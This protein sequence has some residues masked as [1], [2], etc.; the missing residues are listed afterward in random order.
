MAASAATPTS[1]SGLNN[2]GTVQ[3]GDGF[4]DTA[5]VG[6][7]SSTKPVNHVGFT[8]P[9][10]S[11]DDEM[12]QIMVEI[13]DMQ[14]LIDNNTGDVLTIAKEDMVKSQQALSEKK[15]TST[16]I[17][18]EIKVIDPVVPSIQLLDTNTALNSIRSISAGAIDNLDTPVW[19][20]SQH[21]KRH[22][23]VS[24]IKYAIWKQIVAFENVD[25][26]D[27][28]LDTT[29]FQNVLSK[30][31]T[32]EF[33]HDTSV[34]TIK[35][36]ISALLKRKKAWTKSVDDHYVFN[37]MFVALSRTSPEIFGSN[38]KQSGELQPSP[39]AS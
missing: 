36:F 28:Q 15:K 16:P 30:S 8:D 39:I 9:P 10:P 18:M 13:K 2:E 22:T 23:S 17:N 4:G 27:R 29:K 11:H 1:K 3:G 19:K 26:I 35:A 21:K 32:K 6:E 7:P 24:A 5:M 34:S 20:L 33:S 38:W 12:A 14:H 37:C 31:T 25:D